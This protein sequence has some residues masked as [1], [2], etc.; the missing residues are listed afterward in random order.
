MEMSRRSFLRK[1]V[2]LAT[3]GGMTSSIF[4]DSNKKPQKKN[5]NILWIMTDQQFAGAM[6][7]AGCP[8]LSTPAMDQLA[9]EGVLFEK[10]YCANP[11]CVPSRCSMIT[12][13]L[14]HDTGVTFNRERFDLRGESIGRVLK[15]HGY[16]T[17]Y[18]GKWHITKPISDSDWH[19][20]DTI[21]ETKKSGPLNDS[22]V[23]PSC[24]E[25]LR[26]TDDKPF[27]LV[28][29]FQNP[30]DICEYAR[31]L[32]G[33]DDRLWN[34]EIGDIPKISECPVLP[35]NHE[36]SN[37]E[38]SVIR[39]HQRASPRTYPVTGWGEAQWR[40]YR[41]AYYRMIEMVDREILKI[42]QALDTEGK[43]NE[44]IIIFTSDHGDGAGAHKWNQKTL[45]YEESARVP[46]VICDPL[47]GLKG[48]VNKRVLVN[49]GIDLFATLCDYGGVSNRLDSTGISLR[50][51]VEGRISVA[52]RSFIVSQ[53]DLHRRYGESGGIFGRMLRS[54]QH[55]YIVYSEGDDP[56]QLFNLEDDPGEMRNLATCE[57]H[58]D[59]LQV[60][61]EALASWLKANG[62]SFITRT[63][64]DAIYA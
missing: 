4:A 21:R 56:E 37:N 63:G 52:E 27:F 11:I 31:I 53:N 2:A 55:K 44:T 51:V 48:G 59:V 14:P 22:N 8:D 50:S 32:E 38:P 39:E 35:N 57:E 58:A 20:F 12:G 5:P 6:S 3:A 1:G 9:R 54:Q 64:S 49:T 19:G 60:H 41:W 47:N 25:Y 29:S 33:M 13:R 10:A 61:R 34:G 7:C 40:A 45:F 62:D 26:H 23:A 17:G 42:L 46:L 30:H 28:A 36:I 18:F 16:R 24:V 43:K 15:N